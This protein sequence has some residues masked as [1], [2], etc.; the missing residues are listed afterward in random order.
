MLELGFDPEE[1]EQLDEDTKKYLV[2]DIEFLEELL[3]VVRKFIPDDV[4]IPPSTMEYCNSN[5]DLTTS[6]LAAKSPIWQN[7]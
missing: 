4:Y 5:P 2:K 6:A 1:N 3:T 7:N